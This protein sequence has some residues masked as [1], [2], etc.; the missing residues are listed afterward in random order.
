MRTWNINNNISISLNIIYPLDLLTSIS[1]LAI[2]SNSMSYIKGEI[3][4]GIKVTLSHLD[5]FLLSRR[6]CCH[7]FKHESF[8]M[9]FCLN[10]QRHKSPVFSILLS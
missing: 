2:I 5:V 8:E 3:D 9:L 10:I 1:L 4:I 6:L 7:V